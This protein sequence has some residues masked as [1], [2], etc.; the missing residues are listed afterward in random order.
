MTRTDDDTPTRTRAQV[1]RN[2]IFEEM[3]QQMDAVV[4]AVH[5]GQRKAAALLRQW[6]ASLVAALADFPPLVAAVV[7]ELLQ[8]AAAAALR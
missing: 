5:L 4:A 7:A 3:R 6:P 2:P 1:R 8:V